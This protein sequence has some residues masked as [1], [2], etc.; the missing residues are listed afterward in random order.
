MF[1]TKGRLRLYLG[2]LL[3]LQLLTCARLFQVTRAGVSDFRTFYTTGHML[4]AG[5]PLYDYQAEVAAQNALVSP[6]PNALPFMFPPYAALLFVP[7]TFGSY[8]AG[9]FL[10]SA[11]NLCSCG[12]A[13]YILRP[14]TASLE[15]KWRPLTSLLFLSFFPLGVALSFG[16]ISILLL[17][18]YCACFAAL[19]TDHP[20][21]AGIF[22]SL[23][24]IKF[25]IALPVAFLFLLWR[26]W[27]FITGFLCG[28]AVLT[29]ISVLI[30]GPTSFAAYLRSLISMSRASST[31]ATEPRYG[32]FPQQMPN[33]YG[34]F[35]TVSH[36][37]TWGV[38]LTILFSLLVLLSAATRKPSLPL[39]LLAG[40]LISYHLYLYDL[41]LLLLPMSLVF[42][43][44]IDSPV[45]G[46]AK[47]SLY[48]SAFLGLASFWSRFITFD[49]HFLVALPVAV[50]FV[51]LRPTRGSTLPPAFGSRSQPQQHRHPE[52]RP[53]SFP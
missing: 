37:A 40:L 7:F 9:Y 36:G 44:Y 31:A 2:G 29:S 42:N 27:R 19:Q 25:Q 51:C 11:L 47:G 6:N 1:L 49:S 33:L 16:Q 43:E 45:S 21:V 5:N 4:R 52:A 41:T 10:F 38:A 30:T 50:L 34:L 17:L 13:L 26:Q 24:L 8:L 46:L 23:A 35:H 12:L 28:A 53:K 18:L 32:M 22:L 39:A 20:F 14:Y 48:A 15:T 3:I